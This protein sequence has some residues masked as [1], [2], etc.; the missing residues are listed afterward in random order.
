MI[1]WTD[2]YRADIPYT[3][4]YFTDLNPSRIKLAFLNAGLVP[5]RI[6]TA[7][8]LGF[9]HGMSVNMHAV[10]STVCWYG[11]DF[12]PSHAAFAQDMARSWQGDVGLYD[13]AFAQFCAR[14][15]LPDFD[16]ICLHGIWSWI[17]DENRQIL[18]DFISRKLT[19]GGVLYISYNTHPGWAAMQPMRDFL[20]QHAATMSPTSQSITERVDA[21]LTFANQLFATEPGYAKANPQVASRL[22]QMQTQDRSY[23]AHEFF[24]MSWDPMGISKMATWLAPT[25][26]QWAC[27]ASV[28]D[29]VEGLHLTKEQQ[30]FLKTIPDPIFRQTARDFCVNQPFRKDYWIKGPQH[31]SA[32]EKRAALQALRVVLVKAR[33]DVSLKVTTSRGETQMAEP[34]YTPVLDCL[35]DY[36]PRSIAEIAQLVPQI[37]FSKLMQVITVLCGN[38]TL[39]LAQDDASIAEVRE[40]CTALNGYVLHKSQSHAEF[41]LLASPITGGGIAATQFEQLFLLAARQGEGSPEGW[42]RFAWKVTAQQGKKLVKEGK[43]LETPQENLDEVS[44]MAEEFTRKRLPLLKALEVA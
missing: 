18:V 7:C 10:A 6:G 15:D 22:K 30:E 33:A 35:A 38:G 27:S 1:D 8:E 43:P 12:N 41:K 16:Y 36:A 37:N 9:G 32:F 2:G 20:A 28:L 21:A 5:P 11:T 44:R 29:A 19:V 3:H 14:E 25:K 23:L 17:S 31:L 42:A 40:A 39:E 26:L 13:E 34:D 4:S 24:N